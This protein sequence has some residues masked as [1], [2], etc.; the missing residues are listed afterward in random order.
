MAQDFVHFVDSAESEAIMIVESTRAA[1]DI[2]MTTEN[3][4]IQYH[5]NCQSGWLCKIAHDVT[6]MIFFI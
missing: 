3:D 4:F 6:D 1:P 2:A 5:N